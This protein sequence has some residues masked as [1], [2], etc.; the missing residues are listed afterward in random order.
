MVTVTTETPSPRSR[1]GCARICTAPRLL[2]SPPR[3]CCHRAQG[4]DESFLLVSTFDA[5]LGDACKPRTVDAMVRDAPAAPARARLA[6]SRTTHS[7]TPYLTSGERSSQTK[8]TVHN[9]HYP[10]ARHHR[11]HPIPQASPSTYRPPPKSTSTAQ[12]FHGTRSSF[13]QQDSYQK[14]R[15]SKLPLCYRTPEP[16]ADAQHRRRRRRHRLARTVS[17]G[18]WATT[19]PPRVPGWRRRLPRESPTPSGPSLGRV[20]SLPAPN[21]APCLLLVDARDRSPP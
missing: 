1:S 16:A 19:R 10:R 2:S 17:T 15:I 5:T 7:P 11:L 6:R 4:S 13:Q 21:A 20:V 12:N 9:C 3:S 8:S 18:L 14:I